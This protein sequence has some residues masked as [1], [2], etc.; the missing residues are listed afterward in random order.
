MRIGAGYWDDYRRFGAGSWS[1][2][3]HSG[4]GSEPLEAIDVH[5]LVYQLGTGGA[6]Y[7]A[8]NLAVW[9]RRHGHQVS[10]WTSGPWP[11]GREAGMLVEQRLQQLEQDGISVRQL[12]YGHR[13]ILKNGFFLQRRL[14]ESL[15]SNR[16]L[17]A[18]SPVAAGVSM[19]ANRGTCVLSVH[20][21]DFNFPISWLRL[22]AP[23]IGALVAGSASVG[24]SVSARL[25]RPVRVVPYGVE[26]ANT[27]GYCDLSDDGRPLRLLFVGRLETQKNPRRLIE[28]LALVDERLGGSVPH[29]YLALVG[30]GPLRQELIA[31]SEQ[32]GLGAVIQFMGTRTETTA[33]LDA[34]DYLVMS[35]DFEGLPIIL[36]QAIVQGVPSILT[37]FPSAVE[38]TGKFGGGLLSADFT[39][40]ALADVLERVILDRGLHRLYAENLVVNSADIVLSHSIEHMALGYE[41]VYHSVLTTGAIR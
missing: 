2:T 16:V 20:N 3:G 6:E 15:S 18:H 36:L 11:S 33:L 8:F 29:F 37:P 32:L 23:R 9:Q 40:A 28:A 21:T 19:V 41:D 38:V 1:N 4:K 31:L 25:G 22:M 5:H 35:S 24:A 7:L 14:G 17:H 39:T 10:V 26:G 13:S 12:P 27:H 34:A 30:D